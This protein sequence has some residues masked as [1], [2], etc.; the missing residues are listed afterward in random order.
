MIGNLMFELMAAFTLFHLV[1]GIASL[2]LALRLLRP[3]ER[4]H[5]RSKRALLVAEALCWVYPALAFGC[6]AMAWRIFSA[7]GHH[8]LPLLLAP[9]GWLLLMGAVFA[10]VDFAE[11]GVLGN[12]RER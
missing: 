9:I 4:A 3:T 8:A 5:W 7:G 6:A 2:G 11:D 12:T 1:A 10:I